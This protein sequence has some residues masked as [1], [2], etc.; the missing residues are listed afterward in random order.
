[1]LTKKRIKD[2][3][4]GKIKLAGKLKAQPFFDWAF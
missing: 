2:L 1:M 4:N 3:L